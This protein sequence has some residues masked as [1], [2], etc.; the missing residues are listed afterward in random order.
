MKKSS[1]VFTHFWK[2]IAGACPNTWLFCD[3]TCKQGLFCLLFQTVW[4]PP[5]RRNCLVT[6]STCL[7]SHCRAETCTAWPSTSRAAATQ[8][9]PW[10]WASLSCR[11]RACGCCCPAS[12]ACQNWPYWPSTATAWHWPS[13]RTWQTRWRI[14]RSSPAWPGST[15]ATMWISSQCRSRCSWPCVAASVCAAASPPFMNTERRRDSVAT[16]QTWRP[17]WRSPVYTRRG[18]QRKMIKRRRRTGWSFEPGASEK[19]TRQKM[20][21]CTSVGG[22]RPERLSLRTGCPVYPSVS[23]QPKFSLLC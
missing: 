2:A 5:W 6:S 11:T 16:T 23:P 15:W 9:R 14:P 12:A 17:L 13:W 3:L 8:C 18:M 19:K 10:T 1:F 7:A 4:R 21:Q 22:D 20:C